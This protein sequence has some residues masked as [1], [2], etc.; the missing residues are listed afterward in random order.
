MTKVHNLQKFVD[1]RRELR[2]RATEE[3]NILWSELR[4]GKLG[5]RFRRQHSFGGYILDFYCAKKRL[6]I[7]IDGGIHESVSNKEYDEVRD[8]YFK[9]LDYKVL[10]FKNNDVKNCLNEVV[11]KIKQSY[12]E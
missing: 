8:K 7:E 11:K 5:Y 10:R 9:E 3:E 4:N 2:N 1:R 12:G 6:I